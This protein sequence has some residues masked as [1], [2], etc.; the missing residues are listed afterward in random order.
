MRRRGIL[1][2]CR[3][4]NAAIHPDHTI[5]DRPDVINLRARIG[6]WEVDTVLGGIGRGGLLTC[7]DRKSGYLIV[8]RVKGRTAIETQDAMCAALKDMPLQSITL[9]N[10][11][12]FACFRQIEKTLNTTLCFANPHSPWQR[13]SNEN[14][15]G[16]LRWFFPK[17]Y[18]FHQVT[19]Q[20]LTVVANLINNRPPQMFRVAF[21]LRSHAVLHLI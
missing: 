18:D 11:S 17:G 9:D 15:N 12:E 10:G 8:K 19:G 14:V 7:L 21:S 4:N 1:K 13:G 6:D 5:A 3:G 20:Q 16:L 2:F